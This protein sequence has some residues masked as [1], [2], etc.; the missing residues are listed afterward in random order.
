M[1]FGKKKVDDV[2]FIKA[3]NF[4]VIRVEIRGNANYVSNN[5]SEEARSMMKADMEKGQQDKK[6]GKNKPP[7]DFPKEFAGSLHQST[8]GW[9]GIP[10]ISVKASMVRAASLVGVEMTKAKMCIFT[11]PDGFDANGSG[12]F[13]IVK[14]APERFDS[15]V[16]NSNGSPDIRARGR[17]APGWEAIIT[18]RYDAD[19]LSDTSVVNLLARA[20]V[21]VGVGAGR[22]FSSNSVGQ[23]WGTFEIV[24]NDQN[25]EAAE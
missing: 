15:Y 5:F 8:E 11:V 18:L 20:G 25:Q 19:F 12:L 1:A 23:G 6:R 4:R 7:K 17:F 21:S 13:K 9:Y 14:G 3:P 2:V 16:R 10:D 22:P 24:D